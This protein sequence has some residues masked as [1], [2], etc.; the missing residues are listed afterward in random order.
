MSFPVLHELQG[1]FSALFYALKKQLD[2]ARTRVALD[3]FETALRAQ[4]E[5][6]AERECKK[7]RL[8]VARRWKV[9]S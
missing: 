3:A 9:L 5:T 2:D 7:L 6:L 8:L 4:A 1:E